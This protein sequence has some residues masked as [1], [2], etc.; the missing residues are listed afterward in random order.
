MPASVGALDEADGRAFMMLMDMARFCVNEITQRHQFETLEDASKLRAERPDQAGALT[1]QMYSYWFHAPAGPGVYENLLRWTALQQPAVHASLL[2]RELGLGGRPG[3]AS[4]PAQ[5]AHLLAVNECAHWPR[6]RVHGTFFLVKEA[7]SGAALLVHAKTDAVYEVLGISTSLGDLLRSNG[8]DLPA[9]LTLTLLPYVGRI[10]YDGTLLGAPPPPRDV[11]AEL[12][13]A[14]DAAVADGRVI[15]Q[16]PTPCEAPLLGKPVRID[17][18]Q[19]KPELNGT[20]G[21]ATDFDEPKGRYA[22]KLA[23]GGFLLL[24]PASLTEVDEEPPPEGAAVGEPP[25]ESQRAAVARLAAAPACA[26]KEHEFWVL[27][28]MGYTERDNAEH[29]LVVLAGATPI[30]LS[31][32]QPLF[33]CEALEPTVDE[34][35]S[36]LERAVGSPAWAGRGKPAMV[37]TDALP[38][39]ERLKELLRPAN[40]T[41]GYYPP[42]SEEELTSMGSPHS[43]AAPR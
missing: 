9:S 20:R 17:G 30:P 25:T 10:V 34:I 32:Q 40:I 16:L 29:A 28:R 3:Q 2:R 22:V 21:R 14:V 5:A 41:A 31:E 4:G 1:G 26:A 6:Q 38:I 42:P 36:A 39:V 13:A 12:V 43:S 7:P 24:K 11:E 19:A 8:R 33:L 27:R 18:L 37:A 35:L 15:K 23:A